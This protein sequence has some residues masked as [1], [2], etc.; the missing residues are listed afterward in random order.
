MKDV[1]TLREQLKCLCTSRSL[2]RVIVDTLVDDSQ[3]RTVDG[4]IQQVCDD[5]ILVSRTTTADEKSKLGGSTVS[6]SIPIARIAQ[7]IWYEK[8]ESR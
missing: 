4:T 2:V 7:V 8:P 3:V 6:V 5:F 1:S